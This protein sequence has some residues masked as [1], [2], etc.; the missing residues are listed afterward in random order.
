MP[1][2]AFEERSQYSHFNEPGKKDHFSLSFADYAFK[3]GVWRLLDVLDKYGVKASLSTNGL[4]AEMHPE[5]LRLAAREGHE[6]VGH[7]W[8]NDVL[9]THGD[10]ARETAEIQRVTKALTEASGGQRPVGWTSPGACGSEHT[11]RIL[12]EQGY[13]WHGDDASDDLP[14]VRATSSGP[15]VVMPRV[16]NFHNDLVV[17]IFPRNSPEVFWD[18]FKDTFDQLYAEGEVGSPKWIEITLH[19]HFAG[20]PTFTPTIKKCLDYAKRHDGVWFAR[21]RDLAEWAMT[22]E[23]AK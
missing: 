6:I 10:P 8:A 4:A 22:R 21:K 23:G 2:E 7:G 3:S 12:K 9:M 1:Y 5:A 13:L 16:N 20:R 15:M 18:G 14:F 11:L 19:S 17:W